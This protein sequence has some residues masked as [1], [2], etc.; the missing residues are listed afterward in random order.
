MMRFT[1]YVNVFQGNGE[2]D[3]PEP[4]GPAAKWFFIKAGCG[5]TSPAATMPFGAMSVSP[6]TGGY[7]TGYGDHLPNS[8]ARPKKFEEGKKL[9]GFSHLHQS[10]T[11]AIGYYYNYAVTV[12][13]YGEECS[14]PAQFRRP[15]RDEFARPGYYRCYLDGIDC[16]LTATKHTALHRYD[17]PGDG[18]VVT[19]DFSNNGLNIPGC[20]RGGARIISLDIADAGEGPGLDTVVCEAVIEGISV[21]YAVRGNGKV[22]LRRDIRNSEETS[23]GAGAEFYG[24]GRTAELAVAI[25]VRSAAAALEF[26]READMGF[27]AARQAADDAWNEKLSC[28]IID[29]PERVK[30]IFYSNLYHSFVK[31]ADRRGEDFVGGGDGAFTADFNTLWDMYKTALPL[32]FL[33]DRRL[34]EDICE[35]LLRLGETLGFLPN[36]FGLNGRYND[37]GEQARLLAGY[38]LLTA[39]RFGVRVDP[40]R[41]LKVITDD[42]FSPGKSDFVRGEKPLSHTF[43]LDAAEA[44]RLAA[45]L[46]CELGDA[47][48]ESRIRPLAERAFECWDPETGLLKNDTGYYEGSLYNYSF[49]QMVDMRRRIDLA[50]GDERFVRLLDDFFGYGRPDVTQPTDPN[51]GAAVNEGLK[52]G[53]FEGF[54]NESDTEAPYSYIYAGR[55]DRTCEIVRSGLEYM[56]TAGRGGLPGNN[57]T[58]ALSSYYC[59]AALG[60]FPV[61]GQDLFFLGSPIVGSARIRLFNGRTLSIVVH[62]GSDKAIYVKKALWKGSEISGFSI[63]AGE[64]V[65]GGELEFFMAEDSYG[66]A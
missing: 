29:A 16:R 45:D 59:L 42:V 63:P 58:G 39:Y 14:G 53:R 37:C 46:A 60:L 22:R 54:N 11:G 24:F 66:T 48:T 50:G 64:L 21:Y 33:T 65:G 44:C 56:F 43:T 30:E 1:D 41:I 49:R 28:I 31:P 40:K 20:A 8:F 9:I 19:V 25:S 61:A 23:D 6:Y 55:H 51:D 35:T 47:E 32:I 17:F 62:G 34:G 15:Y 3:L 36:A 2:I 26:L 57:D 10:G 52:L 13:G 38:V 27:D 18:G 4:K 7:P 12:P 5:N